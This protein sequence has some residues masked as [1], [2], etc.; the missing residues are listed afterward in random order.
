MNLNTKL[1]IA[2]VKDYYNYVQHEKRQKPE[3]LSK[4]M[5]INKIIS[6][7][8][9][10]NIT[11]FRYLTQ[12][13]EGERNIGHHSKRSAEVLHQNL[14]SKSTDDHSSSN[15]T[16]E[17]SSI[18]R[19]ERRYDR[20]DS[21]NYQ[22]LQRTIE[23]MDERNT[24][25]N[26]KRDAK[27]QE[28][29]NKMVLEYKHTQRE[30]QRFM[31]EQAVQQQAQQVHQQ[32]AQQ[33]FMLQLVGK[34]NEIVL[35]CTQLIARVG[36]LNAL[37]S[38]SKLKKIDWEDDSDDSV[39]MKKSKKKSKKHKKSKKENDLIEERN[40]Y[41]D[42]DIEEKNNNNKNKKKRKR[43]HLNDESSDVSEVS[44]K[45]LRSQ[46]KKNKKSKKR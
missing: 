22:S 15:T 6:W 38:K 28:F 25:S 18:E 17:T 3:S 16:K 34:V 31:R 42:D 36:E 5:M 8:R 4:T 46:K 7:C 2:G 10:N 9:L 39:T 29:M 21:H 35:P 30:S 24:R 27:H 32:A 45:Y 13:A 12:L 40:R 44:E 20:K 41:S 43:E 37:G 23:T 26:E 1:T 33:E 11:T 19:L 14:N